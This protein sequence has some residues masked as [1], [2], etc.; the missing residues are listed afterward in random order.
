MDDNQ[1]NANNQQSSDLSSQYQ[2]ILNKY[3][4]ELEKNIPAPADVAPPAPVVEPAVIPVSQPSPDLSNVPLPPEYTPAAA[5]QSDLPADL[6]KPDESLGTLVDAQSLAPVSVQDDVSIPDESS[7]IT[8]TGITF[9]KA[10]EITPSDDS[11][12]LPK[13]ILDDMVPPPAPAV[14]PS[15]NSLPVT[16]SPPLQNTVDSQSV[17]P[18][19]PV[20]PSPPAPQPP[21]DA[22]TEAELK[23][24][25]ADILNDTTPPVTPADNNVSSASA[26]KK[27]GGFFKILFFFCLITFIITAAGLGYMYMKSQS[28]ASN[29]ADSGGVVPAPAATSTP[30]IS[31]CQL[32]DKIYGIGET[33]A[34]AD[35]ISTCTCQ[36][37]LTVSCSDLNNVSPTVTASPSANI[38]PKLYSNKLYSFSFNYPASAIVKQTTTAGYL[39]S[40][41][42]SSISTD[43]N[44]T[45][46]LYVGTTDTGWG[47]YRIQGK[48]VAVSGVTAYR[49]TLPGGQNPPQQV[50]IVPRD[51]QYYIFQF[52]WDGKNQQ[53]LD[54]FES[55]LTTFKFA[56]TTTVTPTVSSQ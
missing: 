8:D 17:A 13:S 44:A 20:L 45:I 40:F 5:P 31:A 19:S 12:P 11:A 36:S 26:P 14:A 16:Q 39:S 7:A 43:N 10:P 1:Q 56:P 27:S 24:K 38:K 54:A 3:A 4:Q 35:G 46:T 50:V 51:K 32:N 28:P 6:S 41:L 22:P 2:D 47:D 37:D 25:L 29:T 53:S 34:A 48:Q 15:V 23:A 18:P 30:V 9:D 49:E 21:Q 52:V 42:V 55:V 33:F